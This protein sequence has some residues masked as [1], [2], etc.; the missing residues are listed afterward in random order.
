MKPKI[1]IISDTHFGHDKMFEGGLRPENFNEKLWRGF[2]SLS[3][4]AILIHCGDIISPPTLDYFKGF[5]FKCVFGNND[6]ERIGLNVK[7]KSIGFEEISD[8]K[9]FIYKAK[10]IFASSGART[11]TGL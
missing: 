1:Y 8:T 9:D 11:P 10:R 6:G 5:K 2:D 4:D 3:E 7:A